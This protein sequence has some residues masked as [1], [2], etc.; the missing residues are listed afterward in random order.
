LRPLQ[1]GFAVAAGI[2]FSAL[3]S[4][5]WTGPTSTP[6]N[7]N[8]DAPINVGSTAQFKN[9]NIGLYGNILLAA[10]GGSYLNFGA[11]SGSTGY[12]IR[13]NNGTLE[14]KNSGGV[15]YNMNTVISN[16][17]VLNGLT[18]SSGTSTFNSNLN[19]NGVFVTQVDGRSEA[20]GRGITTGDVMMTRTLT[21]LSRRVP[22][23]DREQCNRGRAA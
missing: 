12:G 13:D 7:G 15:W 5:A 8:A 17:L 1:L 21:N 4:F 22:R 16:Y 23:I 10:S 14:F 3:F 18:L 9:G 2:F 20:A 19:V 6:P 11:T